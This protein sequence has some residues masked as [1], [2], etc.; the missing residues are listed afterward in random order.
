MLW[1]YSGLVMLQKSMSGS[2]EKNHLAS[3]IIIEKS[4]HEVR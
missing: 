3:V 4:S 1:G 2:E